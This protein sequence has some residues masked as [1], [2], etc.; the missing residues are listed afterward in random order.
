MR[1]LCGTGMRLVV[2]RLNIKG[3]EQ[4]HSAAGNGVCAGH[5]YAIRAWPVGGSTQGATWFNNLNICG[6][7]V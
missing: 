4:W 1:S 5:V 3:L 6:V 7:R 2:G